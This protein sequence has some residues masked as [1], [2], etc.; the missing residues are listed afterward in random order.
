MRE[1]EE[2]PGHP[3]HAWMHGCFGTV[4]D[5]STMLDMELVPG[6][7]GNLGLMMSWS[8]KVGDKD[9]A[10]QEQNSSS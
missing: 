4:V 2:R 1:E 6:R 5:E 8:I 10:Y 3:S 9:K 7:S